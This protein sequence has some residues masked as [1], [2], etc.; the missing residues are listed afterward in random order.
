MLDVGTGITA[1]LGAHTLVEFLGHLCDSDA[2]HSDAA[3]R[4]AGRAM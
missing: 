1:Y 2:W 4:E 3:L